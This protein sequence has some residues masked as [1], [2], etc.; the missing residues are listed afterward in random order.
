VYSLL[1]GRSGVKSGSGILSKVYSQSVKICH[2]GSA[3]G[4]GGERA[5]TASEEAEVEV[6]EDEDEVWSLDQ[7]VLL[8]DFRRI[9]CTEKAYWV[10]IIRITREGLSRVLGSVS[11][12]KRVA[13]GQL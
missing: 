2:A 10:S 6:E 8:K 4:V 12:L 1:G 9:L 13:K 5:E 11:W 3:F 7:R